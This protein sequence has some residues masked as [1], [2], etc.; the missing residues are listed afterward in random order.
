MNKTYLM[1]FA[2]LAFLLLGCRNDNFDPNDTN[3]NQQSLKFRVVS[4]SE[5]PQ[6]INVLQAKTNFTVPLK[7]HSSTMGKTET[8][9]GE[10]NTNYIIETTNGTDE[11]FYT[12][13]IIPNAGDDG[14]ETYN[15]VVKTDDTE[16]ESAKVLVYEPAAEWVLSG[17]NDYLTFSGKVYTYALDGNLEGTVTYLNGNGNCDPEP[18]TD[19]PTNPNG[20]GNPHGPGNGGGGGGTPGGGSTPGGGGGPG[21]GPGSGG[22]GGGSGGCVPGSW[23][24]SYYIRDNWG[25]AIGAVYTNGCETSMIMFKSGFTA[26]RAPTNTCDQNQDPNGG[27]VITTQNEICAKTK[28]MVQKADVKPKL[29]ELYEKSKIGGEKAFMVKNDGTPGNVMNGD[30]HSVTFD[31]TGSKGVYHNHTPDGIKMVSPRDIYVLLGFVK[32]L[33]TGTPSND[34]FVGMVGSQPCAVAGACPPDGYESFNYILRFSDTPQN[35]GYLH[36]K[37]YDF[38]AL[39]E[40]YKKFENEVRNK[41]GNGSQYG[42]YIGH[43]ALEE[44]FFHALSVMEIDKSKM[45][46]QRID[47]NGNVNNVTLG[48][49]GRPKDTPCP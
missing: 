48:A 3:N 8:V 6:I 43:Q 15:L 1:W 35:A 38:D 9:F 49:D 45:I 18:C 27:V 46:L 28:A 20:P 7:N 44:V 39:R 36:D 11:V 30:E 23:V 33:P 29:N 2:F 16:T 41:P 47:K 25:N 17:N 31:M 26:N 42:N 40:D 37:T 24:L 22:S 19:C 21:G 14:S 12:F 32:S 10:I 13:P 34:A 5:I 4:R